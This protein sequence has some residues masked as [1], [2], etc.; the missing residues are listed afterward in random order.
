MRE[1]PH[2]PACDQLVARYGLQPHPEGGFYRRIW[3]SSGRIAA[4]ALP[5]CY[6]GERPWST[7]IL[8]LL[9]AGEHSRLH[10]LHSDEIWHF[11][12][13]GPL[14]LAVIHP[15]G[16]GEDHLLGQDLAAG[17][18]LVH[19]VPGGCWFGAMPGPETSYAL[20]GCTVAPGFDFADFEL[21]P[22]AGHIRNSLPHCDAA[23]SR[24]LDDFLPR[25]PE[26][27]KH[28]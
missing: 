14:R 20:V 13:G 6:A 2:I 5:P 21:A 22:D 4:Q 1:L 18:E 12:L 25:V 15:D 27:R 11:L 24:I 17:Q 9:R 16:S 7:S 8:F 19:V 28:A 26:M 23:A 3:C 10:R